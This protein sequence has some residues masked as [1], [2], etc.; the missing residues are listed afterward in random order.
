MRRKYVIR[1]PRRVK[2]ALYDMRRLS[3]PVTCDS[4]I[5]KVWDTFAAESNADK[6]T[7]R[8]GDKEKMRGCLHG[9]SGAVHF[10][11]VS[12]SP[13]LLV[14]YPEKAGITPGDET[15]LDSP[16]AGK[17]MLAE[18]DNPASLGQS[19]KGTRAAALRRLGQGSL[20]GL[21]APQLV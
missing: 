6:K 8:Q 17:R 13:C 21:P 12:L 3:F 16:P 15:A 14:S 7:E 5:A 19:F 1:L 2:I 9:P 20:I 18:E 10:L 4:G 11:L